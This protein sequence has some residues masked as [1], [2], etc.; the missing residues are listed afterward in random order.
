MILFF[1]IKFF[2]NYGISTNPEHVKTPHNR[3]ISIKGMYMAIFAGDRLNLH[4]F[5]EYFT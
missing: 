5:C 1:S 4:G 3:V 2:L